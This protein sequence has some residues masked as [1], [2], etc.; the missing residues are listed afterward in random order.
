MV[1]YE[2][3]Q[4]PRHRPRPQGALGNPPEIPI[5]YNTVVSALLELL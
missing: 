5:V 4:H 2:T 1:A 3:K